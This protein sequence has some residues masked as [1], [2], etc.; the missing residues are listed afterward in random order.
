M[1]QLANHSPIRKQQP[2]M[3]EGVHEMPILTLFRPEG[4]DLAGA[5]RLHGH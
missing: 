1:I 5:N 3:G 4:Y 2:M